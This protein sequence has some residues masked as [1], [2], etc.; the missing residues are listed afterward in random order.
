MAPWLDGVG[1]LAIALLVPALGAGHDGQ[2]LLLGQFAGL[3]D[4]ACAGRVHGHGLLHEDVLA[5]L[6]RRLEV[7]RPECGGVASDDHVHVL[8]GQELAVP[9]VSRE[10]PVRRDLDDTAQRAF[11]VPVHHFLI[12]LTAFS[13]RPLKGSARA[14]I[15]IPGE[16][17]RQLMIAPVPRPP[18]PISPTRRVSE[19]AANARLA[20][21]PRAATEKAI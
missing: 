4:L 5:G 13:I 6:D 18:H 9:V 15:S 2:A 21:V 1:V 8:E 14:T 7:H 10:H 11:S 12:S 3:D 20:A 17:S 16:D 19:P